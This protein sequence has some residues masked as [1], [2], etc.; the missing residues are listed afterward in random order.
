MRGHPVFIAQHATATCCR[1]CL[2]K[3]HDIPAGHLLTD[4]EQRH[5]IAAIVRWIEHGLAGGTAN[6]DTN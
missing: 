5:I 1:S 6:P 4:D 3:W 2:A